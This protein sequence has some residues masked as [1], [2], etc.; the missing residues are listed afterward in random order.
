MWIGERLYFLSD[1]EGIGNIYS[2]LATGEDLCRHTDHDDFYARNPT[3]DGERI[4]YHAGGDLY[5][6]DPEADAPMRIDVRVHSSRTELNRRFISANDYLT[7]VSIHPKG[8]SLATTIRGKM[9]T[10]AGWEGAVLQH[11]K[12][13][14]VRYR[15]A[16][17]SSD[18][19][20]L[21][22][23]S[24]ETGEESIEVHD[25]DD[26]QALLRLEGLAIGLATL[27][28]VS[29]KG[30]LAAVAN[31]R[32]ELFIV[33][34]D[35]ATH[36][37]IDR[38]EFSRVGDIAWSPDGDWI[39]YTF[40]A[41]I[42]SMQL[43]LH[44]VSTGESQAL[45]A[46]GFVDLSPSF[47]PQGKYLYFLSYREFNPVYDS[48]D[49]D[50]G[51]PHGARPFAIVLQRD[52][53]SP[54]VPDPRPVGDEMRTKAAM[55]RGDNG[56][57]AAQKEHEP[58]LIDLDGIE[59][60]IVAFPVPERR[61]TRIRGARGKAFYTSLP[62]A[63]AI[64]IEIGETEQKPRGL[65]HIFDLEEQRE[66]GFAEKVSGFDIGSDGR[67]VFYCSAKGLRLLPTLEVPSTD[68]PQKGRK[69]GW[70]DLDRVPVEVDPL[71]EWR[72]MF[73]ESW[74]LIRD[75]FWTSDLSNVDWQQVF[76]RYEPLLDRI[77]T[78]SELSDLLWEVQGELGTSHAYEMAGDYRPS[79]RYD[80]GLLG[81]D[82][83]FDPDSGA[84]RIAHIVRGDSW[85]ARSDSPLS[86]AGLNIAEGDLVVA[87]GG[88][89][90][91]ASFSPGAAMV[92]QAGREVALKIRSE[93]GDRTVSVKALRDESPSRYREWVDEN[94]ARVH[95]ESEGRV[96]YV[97][98]PDMGPHGFAEFHR[99]FLAEMGKDALIV[100][101]RFNRGGHVSQLL[102]EKL[103]R[104]PVG[105]SQPR[106]GVPA[107]YPADSIPGPMVALTNEFAG[108]DGDIFS[109]C[110]KLMKLGPLIGTRTWGGVVGIWP[111][112]ALV[113]G[114]VTTQ[115]EFSFWF[116]D[117]AWGVE[118]HGTDPDIEV[119]YRPQDYVAERDPQL[120]R[121]ISEI[122]ELLR[123]SPDMPE[124]GERPRRTLPTLP[125]RTKRHNR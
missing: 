122:L 124:L 111:R 61:Y 71:S 86:R 18:G 36:T 72:Q 64:E 104:K 119:L 114:T 120:E 23:I 13:Q 89:K 113:D 53:P 107:S 118:G 42:Q 99:Y 40:G 63:G 38:S 51:F 3:T 106:W 116:N 34:L 26:G 1:H 27:M 16:Q 93:S 96:G 11:G 103:A 2:C 105:Y 32:F 52:T 109:H 49:F 44:R 115:P 68:L 75:N 66:E 5:L 92:H 24:D 102:L 7:H 8:H 125:P 14:G 121:G 43:K 50:L 98:V 10:F 41:T 58:T 65:L 17:W 4:V 80:Q 29:P 54:F 110:F 73:R 19:S 48:H 76:Q 84:Y 47:D 78:R 85:D 57:S 79:P 25:I 81:A 70:I 39:C 37:L 88:K 74:R 77:A 45:T 90:L 60:R 87:I 6:L 46:P 101:A 82:F 33:D 28:E 95:R 108:S 117:V 31:Q 30:N 67:V 59:R 20:R 91:S 100:D 9:H 112:R 123:E 21:I 97:H 22:C 12:T 83:E 94:R 69:G 55:Q 15:S 35:N 56:E 62:I